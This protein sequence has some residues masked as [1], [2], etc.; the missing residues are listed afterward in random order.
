MQPVQSPRHLA[1]GLT[2]M[3]PLRPCPVRREPSF[4]H[5][6]LTL[7]NATHATFTWHRNQDGAAQAS[8]SVLV[9]RETACHNQRIP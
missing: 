2:F 3:S 4:G 1:S 6:M 9:V 8:D 5:G 7:Q